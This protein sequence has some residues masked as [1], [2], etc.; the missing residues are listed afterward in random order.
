MKWPLK[1]TLHMCMF[2]CLLTGPWIVASAQ[3]NLQQP[4]PD[5]TKVNERDKDKSQ[6]TADQQKDNRSDRDITQQIRQSVVK[7]KA[8]STYAHN[9]KI[10][11]QNGMVTLKGPVRSDEE[12]RAVEAKAAEIVGQDKVTS[13]LEV[14]P[15]K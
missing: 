7:D 4:A 1:L 10:I 2:T 9:V 11:S 14:K 15:K 3:D 13:E 12:K 5:N 8:L 6:P